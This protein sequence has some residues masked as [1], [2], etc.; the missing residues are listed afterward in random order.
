MNNRVMII[1]VN[2]KYNS[3]NG[4]CDTPHPPIGAVGEIISG[5]DKYGEYDIMFDGYPCPVDSPDASWV[6]H[7]SMIVFIDND[8]IKGENSESKQRTNNTSYRE[9]SIHDY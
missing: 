1:A 3:D 7:K 8:K 5:L 6:I 2:D 4:V 9:Y